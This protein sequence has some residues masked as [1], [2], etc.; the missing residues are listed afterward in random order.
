MLLEKNQTPRMLG[1]EG[2][3][4]REGRRELTGHRPAGKE[5][6]RIS[7]GSFWGGLSK[8][9]ERGIRG[10]EEVN[11]DGNKGCC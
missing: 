11:G 5:R 9:L 10:E 7:V 4:G 3:G 6:Q 8:L 1:V 2:G